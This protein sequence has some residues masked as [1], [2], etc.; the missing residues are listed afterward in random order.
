MLG[1]I[2]YPGD[3]NID[4]TYYKL[5]IVVK[6]TAPNVSGV[7]TVKAKSLVDG[8][9]SFNL[10]LY[11]S[12]N[13]SKVTAKNNVATFSHSNEILSI[14]LNNALDAGEEIDVD[15]YY[16]G[17]PGSSGFGSFEVSSH[18]GVPAIW[19]LSEPY[20]ASDWFP[21]KDTP[22]DKADSADVWVTV[23]SDMYAVSNGNLIDIID[24]GN[25]TKT[26]KWKSRYPIAQY[27][28]SMAITNYAIYENYFVYNQGLDTMTLFHYNYPEK[29]NNQRRTDLNRT[30]DMLELFSDLFGLYPFINEKYG[31]AEFG[32]GGGMEHQTVSSMG[33]FYSGIVAHELAHQWFGDKITCK[34]WRHIWL[35]EGFATY[36]EG[37][38]IEHSSGMTAYQSFIQSKMSIAANAIGSIYVQNISSVSQIFSSS[39]SYA[40][41]SVVLHMLRGIL[42][43]ETFYDVLYEYAN[44]PELAYGVAETEDFQRIAERVSGLDLDYFFQDWI[45]GENYPRYTITWSS[46]QIGD[47]DYQVKILVNQQTNSN[48]K[49]FTMPLQFSI[50]TSTSDTLVTLFNNEQKQEFIVNLNSPPFN[51][52]FDPENWIM[53]TATVVVGVEDDFSLPQKFSLSQ[54]YP[55]PFNPVT[56]IKY[57]IPVGA[58]QVILLRIYDILGNEVETLVNDVKAPGNYEVEFDASKFSSGIYFYKLQSGGFTETR[59]LAFIK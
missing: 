3:P 43:T 38:Y 26:F 48:P 24:N 25:N 37:V 56:K 47:N 17:N 52:I 35:N 9:N 5:D 27:L 41:G 50:R 8:L 14:N 10:D 28:I 15:I 46:S 51:I 6:T 2:N 44:D 22:A 20:G 11:S 33:A 19:T 58:N 13:V 1:K 16:S 23:A 49:F 36:L 40:K 34:D 39:R 55:N 59:K 4:V 21:C 45:Y 57:S 12:M 29:L 32:W 18:N 7:T 30:V 42:G 53:K 31:H 54:N